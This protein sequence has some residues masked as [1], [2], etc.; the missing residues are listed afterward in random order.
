M[1]DTETLP[2]IGE[3]IIG[4]GDSYEVKNIS[5]S[6]HEIEDEYTNKEWKVDHINVIL[7]SESDAVKERIRYVQD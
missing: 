7:M 1:N 2:R 3:T 6:Y 5:Y 4:T